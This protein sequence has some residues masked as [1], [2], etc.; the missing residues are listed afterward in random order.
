MAD[1]DVSLD[2]DAEQAVHRAEERDPDDERRQEADVERHSGEYG[3][4]RVQQHRDAGQNVEAGQLY[5][6]HVLGRP[7]RLVGVNG[8]D[9]DAVEDDGGQPGQEVQRQEALFHEQSDP[10][11]FVICYVAARLSHSPTSLPPSLPLS[12]SVQSLSLSLSLSLSI[13]LQNTF[14]Y[15]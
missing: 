3:R 13:S 4:R 12:L 7:Q 14:K 5:Q 15:Q 9:E 8:G 2:R 1:L 11:F 10:F 6:Q